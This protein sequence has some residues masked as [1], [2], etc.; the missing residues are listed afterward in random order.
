M[1]FSVQG[2]EIN[3]LS[4][5]REMVPPKKVENFLFPGSF[6]WEVSTF[7]EMYILKHP[8]AIWIIIKGILAAPPQSY[9]PQE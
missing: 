8:P 9:P 2:H 1:V 6:C 4:T 3:G 5:S 7:K